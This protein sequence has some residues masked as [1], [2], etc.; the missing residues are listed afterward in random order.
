MHA[1]IGQRLGQFRRMNRMLA[2]SGQPFS[3]G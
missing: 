3:S 1:Q 2:R